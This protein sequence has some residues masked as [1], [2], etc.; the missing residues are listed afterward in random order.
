[1]RRLLTLAIVGLLGVTAVPAR[2]QTA[3]TYSVVGFIADAFGRPLP[4]VQVTDQGQSTV[5]DSSGRY[6]LDETLPGTYR[7]TAF[8]AHVAS[9]SAQRTITTPGATTID[10]NLLYAIA[11]TAD[12]FAYQSG[13]NATLQ[14]TSYAPDP[15]GAD[16]QAS[17]VYTRI[18]DGTWIPSTFLEI[19]GDRNRWQSAVPIPVDASEG[20]SGSAVVARSCADGRSLSITN[21]VWWQV[22]NTPPTVDSP[23][24]TG[25]VGPHVQVSV[26][27]SDNSPVILS[28]SDITVDGTSY[29][30]ALD[31]QSGRLVSSVATLAA[32]GHTA[33]AH[34]ADAA[35]NVGGL[36]F[37]FTV[38]DSAPELGTPT[39]SG[40]ITSRIPTLSIPVSDI[41]SGIDAHLVHMTLASSLRSSQVKAV[42]DPVAGVVRYTV[43]TMPTGVGVGESP[44]LDGDYAVA[45]TI[46]DGAGNAASTSWTFTVAT[47]PRATT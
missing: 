25:I 18:S 21:P 5:T 11:V 32:G 9:Q 33:I 24:P 45:L 27:A 34:V 36:A 29:P 39:P 8:G 17:C 10:F 40:T 37:A 4:N 20:T 15:S 30:V 41:G 35:G 28:Q 22:D 7:I 43:P 1:M 42:Y 44:L 12:S 14:I 23:S 13:A 6:E 38:D 31:G 47:L 26:R 3:A 16:P 46:V 19:Q 2:A